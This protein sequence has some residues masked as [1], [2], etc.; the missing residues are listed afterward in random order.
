MQMN[1]LTEK[2]LLNEKNLFF[3]LEYSFY[4]KRAFIKSDF[5]VILRTT[6]RS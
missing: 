5:F 6:E 2:I 4:F 1:L 3:L